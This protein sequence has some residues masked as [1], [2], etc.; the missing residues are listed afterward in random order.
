MIAMQLDAA[1]AAGKEE[2]LAL[3]LGAKYQCA[4]SPEETIRTL[5]EMA[6]DATGASLLRELLSFSFRD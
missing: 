1:A 4:K 5:R 2:T 3:E 6:A